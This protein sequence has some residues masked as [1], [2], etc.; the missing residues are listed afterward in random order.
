MTIAYNYVKPPT[1]AARNPYILA[2]TLVISHM[3]TVDLGDPKTAPNSVFLDEIAREIKKSRRT[4]VVTGAGVSCSAGIPD[5]RSKE[6]LY[7]MVKYQHPKAVVKGQDLFD[8]NLFRSSETAAVF[9]TFMASLRA[10]M[11]KARPTPTHHFLRHLADKQK[12]LR[13]YT[14]NIDGFEARVGLD[15]STV[16]LHGDIHR[17][18]CT[19]V[20]SHEHDW[21]PENAAKLL[22]GIAPACPE[23]RDAAAAR[24][25]AGKRSRGIGMLRPTIVLYGEEHPNGDEIGEQVSKDARTKPSMLIVAGTS[26]KVEG[27]KHLVKDLA[28]AVHARGGICVFVNK[29]PVSASQWDQVFDYHV[30]GDSDSWVEDLRQRVPDLWLT[31]TRLPTG[32]VQKPKKMQGP[33]KDLRSVIERDLRDSVSFN[34]FQA[35]PQT[36]SPQTLKEFE[37]PLAQRHSTRPSPPLGHWAIKSEPQWNDAHAFRPWALQDKLS[38]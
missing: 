2:R 6:G 22:S 38:T 31:Q 13:V 3:R 28:K 19:A 23:C 17:L 15:R 12:L 33:V 18:R 30:L 16:L 4:V 9:Y 7:N 24:E 35:A 34:V 11:V 10:E 25:V 36:P 5:F 8:R 37:W 27:I 20:K 1:L 21:T 14:Q 29:T 26:L 32:K